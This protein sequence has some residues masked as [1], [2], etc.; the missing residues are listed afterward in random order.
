MSKY[1]FVVVAK[2][3]DFKLKQDDFA[4]IECCEVKFIANN[5]LGLG[6]VFNK[7]LNGADYVVCMHADVKLDIKGLIDH[8]ESVAGKYDVLGLCGCD[9]M[10]V[11]QRPLNWF[12]GSNPFPKNRWGCVTHGEVGNQTSFFSAEKPQTDH[13]VACIDGLCI[14]FTK[15]AIDAGLKF[16]EQFKFSHYDTDISF[17]CVFDKKLKLGTIV[18]KDLQHHSI[19]KSILTPEF[20]I[21]EAKFREKWKTQLS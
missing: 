16:D 9:K 2:D 21:A 5:K 13:E 18:R 3:E 4:A 15:K 8:I 11:G 1:K 14:I 10:S 20:L 17:Q 7:E 12:T 6:E 19:G